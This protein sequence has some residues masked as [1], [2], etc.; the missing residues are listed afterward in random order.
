MLLEEILYDAVCED[1]YTDE[2]G[3]VLTEAA[4]RQFKRVGTAVKRQFRCTAGPKKG[5]I[6]AS[7]QS[8]ATR[9]DPRKV[10]HGRKVSRMRMGVRVRKTKMTKKKAISRMV[11]KMNRRLA[12]KPTAPKKT[13]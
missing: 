12:G 4:M 5:K 6:V 1:V 8:C 13:K 10:R 11:T 2:D 3:N 7:P 9:K